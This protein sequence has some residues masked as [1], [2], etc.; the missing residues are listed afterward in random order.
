MRSKFTWIIAFFMALTFNL[1]FAQEKTI[2]GVVSDAAGPLPGATIV[3]KGTTRA[4]QTDLD[5][6]FAISA[7]Q[8][9]TLEFS[10]LGFTTQSIAV[11]ASSTINVT[12]KED[13]RV[14]DAVQI[15]SYRR[16]P[17]S[18]SPI[19]VAAISSEAIEDRANANVLQSLQGQLAGLNIGTGSGQPGADS[20][21][22]LRGVGSI[23][24]NVEPLFII[25]GIPV[26]EDN[27]R[28]INP[29]DIATINVLKDAAATAIYGNRGAQGVIVITTKRASYNE[30]LGFRYTSQF[31]Y[32]E[33][34]PL[35][36]DL[37]DSR[38]LLTIQK[39]YGVGDGATM[40]DAE[41]EA[42]ARQA[43]T[44]W[45][46]VFFRK[47]V[48]KQHDLAITS[49]SANT[50][51]FTSINYF[52]QDGI[53]INTNLKRFS[54]RNNFAG[55]SENNKFNY[56]LNMN[57]SFSRSNG[58]D[59]AGSNAIFF[60]PFTAAL[61][62]LPYISPYDANGNITN[63]GGITPGDASAVTV[64]QA[65]VVLLNSSR[66]NI[67]VS[68]QF[69]LLTSFNA[70]YNFMKNVSA[71][72]QI[73]ADFT[74]DQTKEILHPESL[75]G[76]FQT[77]ERAN[78]GGIQQEASQRDFRF[79]MVT[80]LNYNNTFAEKHYVDL[81]AYVEYNKQH[82][83]GISFTQRGLDPRLLGTGAAFIAGTIQ[84]DLDNNPATP[85]TNPY[86]ATVGSS[87]ISEGLFSYF[88]NL[89][90]AYDQ[91]F[92]FNA[93]I[94]RDASFRFIKDNQWGTFWSVA[95][96]WN[97]EK[98]SFLQNTFVNQLR[99]R[100]SYGVNGNQ[101]ILN[102]Q[103]TA[104]NFTRSLY[105]S[106]AA[107]NNTNG[108]FATQL[109]NEDLRWETTAQTN[110]GLDF[111]LWNNKF[112][113][114]LEVY[115]K[116]TT[117]LF[118]R[119]PVSPVVGTS[120]LDANVGSLEN[121]GI[122][123]T[124]RYYVLDNA[125]WKILVNANSSYNKN[126]IRELDPA[127]RGIFTQG[128]STALA[129]GKPIGVYYVQKYAGVNPATGNAL[130][131]KA[132]GSL[133][134][135]I[136]ESDRVFLDKSNYPNWQGGFGTSVIYK[137]FEFTTQWAYV[138]D[139][140]RNNLD[141]A[142]VEE[143]AVLDDGGNRTTSVFRAWQNPGDITDVPRIGNGVSAV[144]FINSTDRYLEDGSYLRMRN[145]LLGYSFKEDFLKETP[146]SGLRFFVQAENLLT[147]SSYRGW[148]AEA[149]F[150]TTDRG[151]YPTAKIY[152]IGAVINF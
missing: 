47:G 3:V 43:N 72:L 16:T 41:I 33:L 19:A 148:D 34:M 23:N 122:E 103:Y 56:A 36:I 73:G 55:K 116:L 7:R 142:Q 121:K 115:R 57:A 51:N 62:G 133:T 117:D 128:G 110:F 22:L 28:N 143:T 59:G 134:E 81:T 107:Y 135:T 141:Y 126:Q 152:T 8:G 125:D 20:T 35:N 54:L 52:E 144:S 38:Q 78:F 92:T 100:A 12:L 96:A 1:S 83:D 98:E 93:T 88:A 30:K 104:L 118:N 145:I 79:N 44:Y 48:T 123:L 49:G 140:W 5:G 129:E 102:G 26:D 27:F 132:D 95:G 42:R 138:A 136:S 68:D 71:G 45:T 24:G 105:G 127:Y 149:G 85:L 63:D 76:P 87:K 67:D 46:D 90:Y 66:M 86:I 146:F 53:F 120:S 84:E 151:Q 2:S 4:T 124:L 80:S 15:D 109:A 147:F 17:V 111:A 11:G 39:Q 70:N 58:I 75:L 21:I 18:S 14:L 94:R 74:S 40:S 114:S 131:Y 60:A 97:I 9:E 99:L 137:G 69:R 37:M 108:T 139:I 6:K 25:D 29:N 13:A 77:D 150:R 50:T 113:G 61:R 89:D 31:G 64:N 130:F 101:R 91:R 106:G 119:K 32:N 10:Y 65:P 112:S 82:L